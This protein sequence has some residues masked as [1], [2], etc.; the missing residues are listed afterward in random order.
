M[1]R[2]P[3]GRNGKCSNRARVTNV[4]NEEFLLFVGYDLRQEGP[5]S[6]NKDAVFIKKT[7][8]VILGKDYL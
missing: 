5:S 1:R 3:G 2:D 8:R 4:G 7:M 6:K